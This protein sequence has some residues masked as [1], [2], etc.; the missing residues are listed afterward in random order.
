MTIIKK[1]KKR[2]GSL[3]ITELCSKTFHIFNASGGK[4][5]PRACVHKKTP[6]KSTYVEGGDHQPE[7]ENGLE[8]EVEGEPVQQDVGEGLDDGD[9]SVDGPK[10]IKEGGALRG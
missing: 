5:I 1:K 10:K 6:Q 4:S 9:E 8:E 3:A 2:D 7:Q